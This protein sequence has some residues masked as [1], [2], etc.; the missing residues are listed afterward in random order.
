MH[1]QIRYVR[2]HA[3]TRQNQM[4]YV[5]AVAAVVQF[6]AAAFLFLCVFFFLHSDAWYGGDK[7]YTYSEW[8]MIIT[9]HKSGYSV[10]FVVDY[11]S[12]LEYIVNSLNY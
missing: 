9:E 6:V 1:K 7:L 4:G 5:Y 2:T 11:I 12:I 10:R 8:D 3:R